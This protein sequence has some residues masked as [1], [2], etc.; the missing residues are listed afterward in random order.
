[1]AINQIRDLT[2][3]EFGK[4]TVVKFNKSE[5]K[6][7]Y[8]DCLCTC[9]NSVTLRKSNLISW[10]TTSCG[11]YRKRQSSERSRKLLTTHGLSFHKLYNTWSGMISRCNKQNDKRYKNYGWRWIKVCD[12]WLNVS[13]FIQ[14]MQDTHKDG[15]Q[16]DRVNNDG[17]YC[18]ENCRW[19][20][21][22]TQMNNTSTN[23]KFNGESCYQASRRIG[24]SHGLAHNR[25]KRGIPIEMAFSLPLNHN[26]NIW[27]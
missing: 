14:D 10:N 19:S 11:C 9:G 8:W 20:T 1:M 26:K 15:L 7:V 24:G 5:H 13:N 3:K 22:E 21:R 23:V 2:G 12:E 25:L 17:D 16:L 18:K 4:L 6:I 27:Q